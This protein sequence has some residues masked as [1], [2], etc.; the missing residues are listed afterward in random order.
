MPDASGLPPSSRAIRNLPWSGG[1][2]LIRTSKS[3]TRTT[4]TSRR[5]GEIAD[6]SVYSDHARQEHDSAKSRAPPDAT[7]PPSGGLPGLQD[8]GFL[9]SVE[10]ALFCSKSTQ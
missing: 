3:S 10:K 7:S 1:E 9:W 2:T 5:L 8:G 6:M 4:T